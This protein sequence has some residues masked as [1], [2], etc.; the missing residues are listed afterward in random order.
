[1]AKAIYAF[2]FFFL[3]IFLASFLSL[4]TFAQEKQ[5]PFSY[6]DYVKHE[7]FAFTSLTPEQHTVLGDTLKPTPLPTIAQ[8][9][10]PTSQTSGISDFLL[11]KVNEYRATFGLPPVHANGG[12]CTF[13][14]IRAQEISKLFN[15]DGFNSRVDKHTIPYTKWSR[16]TENIAE[17]ANYK[18]VVNLWAHS[19]EHAANMRDNTPYVCI[20]Q[21]GN[22]YAYE[23]M[24]R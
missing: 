21:S 18:Q 8:A 19:P 22:F 5:I 6:F 11:S 16:A 20:I 12:V 23:G 24:R 2:F 13:A 9:S 15:H 1:M 10:T 14:A 3:L 7:V 17:S 4:K